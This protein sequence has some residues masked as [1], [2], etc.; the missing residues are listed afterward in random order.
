[1][2]VFY[3]ESILS[4]LSSIRKYFKLSTDYPSDNQFDSFL[5]SNKFEQI[6]LVLVDGM[7][8]RLLKKQLSD[9]AFLNT[10]LFKE[11]ST[12]FPSS[13]VPVTTSLLSGKTPNQTC[14]LGWMQYMQEVDSY[15]EMF[16]KRDFYTKEAVDFEVKEHYPNY[17]MVDE[18]L[19]KGVKATR[20]MPS[21]DKEYGTADLDEFFDRLV[22]ENNSLKNRF[23]YGYIDKYDDLMHKEGPGS[24]EAKNLLRKINRRFEDASKKLSSKTLLMVIAD[25][26]QVDAQCL[27]LE[28]TD[29][30]RYFAKAPALEPRA[31]TFFIKDG[32]QEQFRKDFLELLEDEFILLDKSQVIETR[33]FGDH[34]NHP[35]FEK[36]IGDFLAIAKSD[37]FLTYK[38]VNSEYKGMHGGITD[39]EMMVPVIIY[40]QP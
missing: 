1:M 38:H 25:H 27:E 13:T 39:E 15:V 11:V 8:S 37:T 22:E 31:M 34:D 19:K 10:H 29:L 14:W 17:D 12:I 20:I 40:Y 2:F 28:K 9:T 3:S 7:G 30:V 21:F 24:I 26:G 23:V 33:V 36:F 5:K 16:R 32:M 18:M 6:I 35:D 4:Y